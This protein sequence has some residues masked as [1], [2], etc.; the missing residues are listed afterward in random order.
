[1]R[2]EGWPRGTASQA[3][4]LRDAR[5]RRAPQDEDRAGLDKM[6]FTAAIGYRL[7]SSAS[8]AT[9]AECGS[10]SGAIAVK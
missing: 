3:A 7:A 2:L 4:I 6:S 8:R 1:M 10:A 9:M 5:L